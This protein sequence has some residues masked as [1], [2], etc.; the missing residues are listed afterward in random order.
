MNLQAV[1]VI[2]NGEQARVGELVGPVMGQ[3]LREE[4]EAL[5]QFA[6]LGVAR[7][8]YGPRKYVLVRHLSEHLVGKL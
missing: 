4:T 8:E 3:H 6:A 7:D 5:L 1:A 2:T